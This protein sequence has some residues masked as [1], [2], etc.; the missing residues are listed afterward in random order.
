MIV[1]AG[2]YVSVPNVALDADLTVKLATPLLVDCGEDVRSV[3]TAVPPLV[4]ENDTEKVPAVARL[5]L[6]STMLTVEIEIE[7]PSPEIM[8]GLNT[9]ATA[10]GPPAVKATVVL[11][12]LTEVPS[13]NVTE[14][15]EVAKLDRKTN[16]A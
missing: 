11:V 15:L 16:R 9:Q 2:V 14:Q 5:P 13:L 8:P 4:R 7:E 6:R 10:A 1:V 3:V 12:E